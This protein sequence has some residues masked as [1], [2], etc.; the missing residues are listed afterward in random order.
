MGICIRNNPLRLKSIEVNTSK[1]LAI[2][3]QHGETVNV[4]LSPQ[5]YFEQNKDHIMRENECIVS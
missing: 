4:A 3:S 5:E 1:D 2:S